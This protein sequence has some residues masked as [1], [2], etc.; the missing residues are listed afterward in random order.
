M[1]KGSR[2]SVE[3]RRKISE[4]KKGKHPSMETRRKISE[5]MKG[6][7]GEWGWKYD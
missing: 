7:K 2:H 1:R 4:A 5:A 6:E 3:S